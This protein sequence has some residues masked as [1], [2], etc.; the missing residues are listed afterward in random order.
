MSRTVAMLMAGAMLAGMT[1][2]AF[3]QGRGDGRRDRAASGPDDDR[4]LERMLKE[5]NLTEDQQKQVQQILDTRQQALRNWRKENGLAL[6]DRQKQFQDAKKS[7]D[8]DKIKAARQEVEKIEQSRKALH[9]NVIKQ[10]KDVLTPDQL[11]KARKFLDQARDPSREDQPRQGL[12]AP[13]VIEGLMALDLTEDQRT[14]ARKISDEARKKA[15]AAADP[16]EKER[17]MKAAGET[18]EADVLNDQQREKV[19]RLKGANVLLRLIQKLNLT[20]D[21]KKQ[22]KTIMEDAKAQVE[23]PARGQEKRDISR[24]AFK[25]IFDTVLTDEQ[26]K[27]LRDVMQ[28][29]NPREGRGRSGDRGPGKD[30]RS[31]ATSRPGGPGAASRPGRDRGRPAPEPPDDDDDDDLE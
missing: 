14:Q 15:D 12:R 16:A 2:L 13:R 3:A 30:P 4:P 31:G 29:D 18:I 23:K 21:Q 24:Q 8:E 17:I 10:L 5:L 27:Q 22:I 6:K 26:R 20:D 7:G 19:R 9:E 1:S 25:K 11:E 28:K